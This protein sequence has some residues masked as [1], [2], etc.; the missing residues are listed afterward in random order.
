[1]V[2]NYKMIEGKKYMWDGK[3]YGNEGEAGDVKKQ[4]EENGCETQLLQEE[5]K[6]LVYSRRLVTEIVLDGPP[7]T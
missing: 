1:M 6:Y 4:Y 5:G 7:P 3:E 2:D